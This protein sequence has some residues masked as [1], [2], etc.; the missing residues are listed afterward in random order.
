MT[1]FLRL[2]ALLSAFAFSGLLHAAMI[3]ERTVLHYAPDGSNRQDVEVRNPDDETL[4]IQVDIFEVINP[5]TDEEERREVINPRE[6]N[7]LATPNKMAI[8]P[9]GRKLVRLVNLQEPGDKERVFRVNLK[10]ISADVEADQTAIKVLVGYQ[11][12]VMIHPAEPEPKLAATRDNG[13]LKLVNEGNINILMHRGQQCAA[14]KPDDCVDLPVKR[15]YPGNSWELELEKDGPVQFIQS[16][17]TT[18]QSVVF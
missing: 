16:V 7:F 14:D 1:V 9:G 15:L 11:L 4:Y 12:L 3:V 5:G 8:P 18:N 10:P 6:A 13:K 2:A 17:G